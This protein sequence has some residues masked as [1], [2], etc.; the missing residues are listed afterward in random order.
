MVCDQTEDDELITHE[1]VGKNR[2]MME[3]WIK[4]NFKSYTV[5][6]M[7]CIFGLGADNNLLNDLRARRLQD[8]NPYSLHQFYCLDDLVFDLDV[9]RKKN[10]KLVNFASE[11]VKTFE[12]VS[13]CFDDLVA[14]VLDIQPKNTTKSKYKTLHKPKT[15]YWCEKVF[16]LMKMNDY[17]YTNHVIMNRTTRLIVCSTLWHKTWKQRAI[18]IMK[19]YNIR[20]IALHWSKRFVKNTASYTTEGMNVSY[21]YYHPAHTTDGLFEVVKD[22]NAKE[23]IFDVTDIEYAVIPYTEGVHIVNSSQNKHCNCVLDMCR[24]YIHEI[25]PHT[26]VLILKHVEENEF[27]KMIK[28]FALNYAVATS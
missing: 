13:S 21:A 3:Q 6:R 1:Y 27:E 26:Y 18:A 4:T 22:C 24:N 17:L 12:I 25:S 19:R 9:V 28:F 10:I 8:I 16:V 5:V 23:V 14:E 11:P 7:P 15:Q 20:D 2:Y